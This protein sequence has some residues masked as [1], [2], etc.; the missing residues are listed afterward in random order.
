VR[1]S[2]L[3]LAYGAGVDFGLNATYTTR[4][5]VGFRGVYGLLDISD[6]NTS[7]SSDT[8]YV[9]DRT[10]LKTYSAYLGVSFLF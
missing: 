3:G 7:T 1:K 9:L 4:L 5:G 6:N 10:H 2:D 8:Y